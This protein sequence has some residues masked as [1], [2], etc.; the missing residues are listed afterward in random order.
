MTELLVAMALL[1]ADFYVEDYRSEHVTDYKTITAAIDAASSGDNIHFDGSRIYSPAKRIELYGETAIGHGATIRRPDEWNIVTTQPAN[2]GDTIIHVDAVP[3]DVVYR[4]RLTL[5]EH[6]ADTERPFRDGMEKGGKHVQ[7]WDSVA[8]TIEFQTP[9][10]E[11]FPAGSSVFRVDSLMT[12]FGSGSADNFVFDGNRANNDSH[13]SWIY[14]HSFMSWTGEGSVTNST[15]KHQPGQAVYIFSGSN[16]QVENNLFHDLNLSAMHYSSTYQGT[17]TVDFNN[18]VIVRSNEQADRGGH[19]QG[20]VTVS[21]RNERIQIHDNVV[22]DADKPFVGNLGFDVQDWFVSGN[23]LYHV[24]G[25]VLGK[26]VDNGDNGDPT[27]FSFED[28]YCQDC[29]ATE[30][31]GRDYASVVRQWQDIH[32]RNNEIVDG[33]FLVEGVASGSIDGLNITTCDA[34]P[35][36]VRDSTISISGVSTTAACD[37][38]HDDEAEL[39]YD[40]VTGQVTLDLTQTP[41]A[42]ISEALLLL[43]NGSVISFVDS[44]DI[45]TGLNIEADIL[46]ARWTDAANNYGNFRRTYRTVPESSCFF[47]ITSACV[48]LM[49][50]KRE[51]L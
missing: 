23:Q 31:F 21:Y 15:F 39:I 6:G 19:S 16:F 14:G 17:G 41:T 27:G 24:N 51:F 37:L 5:V 12:A 38:T 20:V 49:L 28:N 4:N 48:M 9:I 11:A 45:P 13:I 3:E 50:F 33:T 8:R 47:L 30:I 46:A 44:V 32:F 35:L 10:T 42:G 40:P 18:N 43:A 2:I 36:T 1:S 25:L 22:V 34:N 7:S 29:G 26:L